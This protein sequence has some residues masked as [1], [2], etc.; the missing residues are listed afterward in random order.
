[1]SSLIQ[2]Y[3]KPHTIDFNDLAKEPQ[4]NQQNEMVAPN[5]VESGTAPSP[6]PHRHGTMSKIA[7]SIGSGLVTSGAILSAGITVLA[8][9]E[10]SGGRVNDELAVA[11]VAYAALG[12]LVSA[13]SKYSALSRE[14]LPP[15]RQNVS[16]PPVQKRGTL[17]KV[18]RSLS[19]G[20]IGYTASLTLGLIGAGYIESQCRCLRD[21]HLVFLFGAS[22]LIGVAR[23]IK[24]YRAQGQSPVGSKTGDAPPPSP[25]LADKWRSL[26]P[27]GKKQILCCSLL[28]LT[29]LGILYAGPSNVANKMTALWK[30]ACDFH[31]KMAYSTQHKVV[32]KTK[33]EWVEG[34]SDL[35]EM[36]R[37][38]S[39]PQDAFCAEILFTCHL[40][41]NDSGHKKAS[42]EKLLKFHPDKC[43]TSDCTENPELVTQAAAAI[44][45]AKEIMRGQKGACPGKDQEGCFDYDEYIEI[46]KTLRK[47]NWLYGM[48]GVEPKC[49]LSSDGE[50][51]VPVSLNYCSD[52][53]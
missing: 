7:Q 34:Y 29:A 6:S 24:E 4:K 11:F 36:Q 10:F 23:A 21:R 37:L 48:L 28:G 2:P 32:G 1:M 50:D 25:T 14:P 44:G 3:F 16:N 46:N 19:A 33:K 40:D 47:P 42:N 51:P 45:R 9:I 38:A 17:T 41:E 13:L 30:G 5:K 53:K 20:L 18:A 49:L 26:S 52:V 35:E 8:A 15:P 27:T 12:G 22:A 43:K 31:D 39:L